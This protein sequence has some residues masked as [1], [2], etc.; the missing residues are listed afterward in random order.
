MKHISALLISLSFFYM[1]KTQPGTL[2]KSYGNNGL[3]LSSNLQYSIISSGIQADNKVLIGGADPNSFPEYPFVLFRHNTD[4]SID[5]SFG[6][7]GKLITHFDGYR[8]GQG[9]SCIK[10][11]PDGKIVVAGTNYQPDHNHSGGPNLEGDIVM[12][13]LKLDGSYDSSFGNNGIVITELGKNEQIYALALQ[14]DGKII[15]AGTSDIAYGYAP[16]MLVVRYN[17]D[18]KLDNTFGNGAGY[19]IYPETA[20][21]AYAVAVQPDGRIVLG[22]DYSVHSRYMLVRYMP[23]GTIDNSFGTNGRVLTKFN[24]NGGD[25]LR[26]NSLLIDKDQNIVA[27]GIADMNNMVVAR[28]KPDGSLDNSFDADGTKTLHFGNQPSNLNTL[29][30]QDDGKLLLAGGVGGSG[31]Y[32]SD[33]ALAR[34]LP[35][36]AYDSSFGTNGQVVTDL[37]NYEQTSHA[38]MQSDG[39]VVLAG[40]AYNSEGYYGYFLTRYN[41]YTPGRQPLAIRIKRWLQHHG[42][43][44]QAGNNIRYYAVQRSPD[45]IVYKEVAKLPNSSNNYEDATALGKESY[46]RLMAIAKDGSRTYSNTVLIDESTQVRM[47]PNPVKD[48]LQL[49]GLATG[50][51]TAVSV[52]DLQGNVR[53]TATA[54]GGSYSVNTANLTPGH[55]LLKLQHNGT[56]TTQAFVKE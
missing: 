48:N 51:K 35:D 27:G 54:G 55:Y 50:G 37:G 22:G 10:V 6:N 23:D 9:W 30:L 46:Y 3:Y 49:Q 13:R 20:D 40:S 45:G 7:S 4:G 28:Y 2:D 34:L 12:A 14:A 5:S 43:S 11:Q 47:F 38:V 29:L 21:D 56:I 17:A 32:T 19:A 26:I 33:I 41:V 31:L 25:E 42:I 53:T 52:M 8:E 16:Q 44:W 1:G 36:G 24:E 39:K 15:L 18:G